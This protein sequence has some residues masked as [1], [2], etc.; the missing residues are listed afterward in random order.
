MQPPPPFPTFLPLLCPS[1]SLSCSLPH[2]LSLSHFTPPPPFFRELAQS[3]PP[4]FIYEKRRKKINK[5]KTKT[6]NI[7]AC[8][9]QNRRNEMEPEALAAT[10]GSITSHSHPHLMIWESLAKA[11]RNPRT[12]IQSQ[13]WP[14]R[15]SKS[16]IT[17]HL[18]QDYGRV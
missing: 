7:A 2:L 3:L 11:G 18:R 16:E 10:Q 12:C 15:R 13:F 5:N 14:T 4:Q 8:K 17:I 9:S 1:L 6:A